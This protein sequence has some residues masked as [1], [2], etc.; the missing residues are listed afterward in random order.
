MGT[1]TIILT[2]DET[3]AKATKWVRGAKPGSVVT[4]KGPKRTLPQ[5]DRMWAHLT[6]IARQREHAGFKLNAADWKMLFL[7]QL[8]S[9]LR[10]IPSLDGKTLV[11]LSRSSE[12]T[13]E[14][15]TGMI[16]LIEA[17]AAEH[18]VVLGDTSA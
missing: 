9:E 15:M 2:N 4:F 10:V 7:Q 18:G 17:Y 6:D 14:E 8:D 13:V 12:L 16:T 1:A 3:R 5:N 11:S